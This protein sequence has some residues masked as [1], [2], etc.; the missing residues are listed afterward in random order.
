MTFEQTLEFIHSFTPDRHRGRIVNHQSHVQH[1]LSLWPEY[2]CDTTLA[3][4]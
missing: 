4:C 2:R 3:F 1:P